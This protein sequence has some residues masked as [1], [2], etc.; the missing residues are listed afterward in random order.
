[1]VIAE[2]KDHDRFLL[3]IDCI[4]FGFDGEKLQVLLIKRK[5]APAKNEWSLMGGFLAM[6]E[7]VDTAAKRVL[8][9]LT[10][11]HDI[12]ME[13][14]ST[15]GEVNRDPGGRVVSISYFALIKLDEHS[16]EQSGKYN[17]GWFS[18]DELP[19]LV[20]DHRAMI[21]LAQ[22]R[23]RQKVANHPVGF[24]LLPDRFTLSQLQ[25][26]YEAIY[27]K[28][29]D[30]SNFKKKMLGLNILQRLEEK[31]KQSSKKG[32]FYYV[33]DREHYQKL[34]SEGLKFI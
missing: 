4:I 13:Q 34:E 3:A 22:E 20:F 32:A 23:L 18:L 12:Y 25:S 28:K 8:Q 15:F 24:E 6:N 1:M 17:A 16:Q 7:S 29:L 33:F 31:D 9:Q 5:M 10:G 14:L 2:Y 11:L 19:P 27:D 21:E 26:L 30:A